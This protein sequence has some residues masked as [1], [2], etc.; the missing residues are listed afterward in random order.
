MDENVKW[1]NDWMSVYEDG[2]IL[3]N[4]IQVQYDE[5]KF[6]ARNYYARMGKLYLTKG[7]KVFFY[8]II[9]SERTHSTVAFWHLKS[10][11]D[12]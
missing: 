8:L 9:C 6:S 4:R 2:F 5:L 12:V 7:C 1:M 3:L 11:V 10:Q